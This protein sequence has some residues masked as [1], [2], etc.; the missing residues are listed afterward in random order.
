[1]DHLSAPGLSKGAGGV[2]GTT[3]ADDQFTDDP[4][5]QPLHQRGEAM[6]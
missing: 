6:R 3:I 2:I 1:M 5:I 4:C